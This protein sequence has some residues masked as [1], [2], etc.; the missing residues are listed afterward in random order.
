MSFERNT[1]LANALGRIDME[2]SQTEARLLEPLGDVEMHQILYLIAALQEER[3]AVEAGRQ[4]NET[5]DN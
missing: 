5:A 2:I 4:G 1:E 3:K